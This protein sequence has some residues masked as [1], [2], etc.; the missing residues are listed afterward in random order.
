M[1]FIDYDKKFFLGLNYLS[2]KD[3]GRNLSKA[4]DQIDQSKVDNLADEIFKCK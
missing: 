4:I 2:L 3:Y 1:N